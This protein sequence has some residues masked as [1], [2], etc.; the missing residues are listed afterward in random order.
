MV[1]TEKLSH[2]T[3]ANLRGTVASKKPIQLQAFG[4]EESYFPI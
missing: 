1:L 4:D 3:Q 2:I